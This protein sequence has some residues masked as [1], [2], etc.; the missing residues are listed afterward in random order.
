MTEREYLY[1]FLELLAMSLIV[2]L[3]GIIYLLAQKSHT[4]CK[5]VR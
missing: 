1:H 4:F 2:F 5:C 3:S